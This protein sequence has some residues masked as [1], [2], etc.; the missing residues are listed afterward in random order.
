MYDLD[1][2]TISVHCYPFLETSYG[3]DYRHLKTLRGVKGGGGGVC[4]FG[5]GYS[6]LI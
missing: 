3:N 6:Y 2:L 1:M 4:K 5:L